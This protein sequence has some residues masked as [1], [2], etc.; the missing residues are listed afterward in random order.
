MMLDSAVPSQHIH[1]L[2]RVNKFIS[3]LINHT[4]TINDTF[5]FKLLHKYIIYVI[6]EKIVVC[7][8]QK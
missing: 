2:L 3:S 1:V 7:I 8:H 5:M 6:H 4:E